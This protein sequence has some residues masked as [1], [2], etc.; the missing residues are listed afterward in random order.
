MTSHLRSFECTCV[1]GVI[2]PTSRPYPTVCFTTCVTECVSLCVS[3]HVSAHDG[4]TAAGLFCLLD[5]WGGDHW[6]SQIGLYVPLAI[7][8]FLLTWS[9]WCKKTV[10]ILLPIVTNPQHWAQFTYSP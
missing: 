10:I 9:G 2:T 1:C 6:L 3:L 7:I 8:Q 4:K 5:D